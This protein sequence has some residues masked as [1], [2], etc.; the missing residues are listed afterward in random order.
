MSDQLKRIRTLVRLREQSVTAAQAAAATARRQEMSAA[1]R[2][3][4]MSDSWRARAAQLS[5]ERT[6]SAGDFADAH[7][8]L[9]ALDR[10][11]ARA[12][13]EHAQQAAEADQAKLVWVDAE[14][15]LDKVERWGDNVET[16]QRAESSRAERREEDA[17]AARIR[18]G[19]HDPSAES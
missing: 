5:D 14:R 10:S 7:A 6:L 3:E 4:E 9:Q 8:H 2:A 17:I 18:R 1:K 15:E 16:R 11:A 19:T 12:R 13:A